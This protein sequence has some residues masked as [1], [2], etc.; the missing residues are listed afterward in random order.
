MERN[1]VSIGSRP[2]PVTFWPGRQL[3]ALSCMAIFLF[4]I[5]LGVSGGSVRARL[6]E[7]LRDV[8]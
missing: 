7:N 8:K 4:L 2:T 5:E 3:S 6:F 1:H